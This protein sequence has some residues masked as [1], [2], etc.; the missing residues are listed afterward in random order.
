MQ[1]CRFGLRRRSA[2]YNGPV[3]ITEP[4]PEPFLI[5]VELLRETVRSF[6]VY[7]LSLP[8][9]RALDTLPLNPKVT[10]FVGDSGAG[11][12]TLLEAI[13]IGLVL[14]AKRGE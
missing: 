14:N 12:S 13:A 7:P 3:S 4:H 10:F 9:V 2:R 8:A 5:H 6:D 11:K 1:S